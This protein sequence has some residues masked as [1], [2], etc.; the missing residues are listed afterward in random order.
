MA[1]SRHSH[2]GECREIASGEFSLRRLNPP[3]E[4]LEEDTEATDRLLVNMVYAYNYP[5]LTP[6]YEC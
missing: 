4:R 1:C 5:F 6:Q 2:D 3:Y